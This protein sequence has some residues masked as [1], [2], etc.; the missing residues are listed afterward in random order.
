M[1]EVTN[2]ST[3]QATPTS[4]TP[5]EDPELEAAYSRL[6]ALLSTW[7]P[8]GSDQV[9]LDGNLL[10]KQSDGAKTKGKGNVWICSRKL[11]PFWCVLQQASGAVTGSSVWNHNHIPPLKRTVSQALL[12]AVRR[13]AILNSDLS[14]RVIY[15][16]ELLQAQAV[17]T[18]KAKSLWKFIPKLS[19]VYQ[20]IKRI[21]AYHFSSDNAEGMMS[22]LKMLKTSQKLHLKKI[23]RRKIKK[24]I[25]KPTHESNKSKYFKSKVSSKSQMESNNIQMDLMPIFRD[26]IIGAKISEQLDVDERKKDNSCNREN[27]TLDISDIESNNMTITASEPPTIISQTAFS[28]KHLSISDVPTLDPHEELDISEMLDASMDGTEL[29]LMEPCSSII[30][31][32][33]I[34]EQSQQLNAHQQS[35]QDS[36]PSLTSP[37]HRLPLLKSG[38]QQNSSAVHPKAAASFPLGQETLNKSELPSKPLKVYSNLQSPL[39]LY[40]QQIL[41]H[42]QQQQKFTLQPPCMFLDN[43]QQKKV[44]VSYQGKGHKESRKMSYQQQNL[45][46]QKELSDEVNFEFESTQPQLS[47]QSKQTHSLSEESCNTLSPPSCQSSKQQLLL[48]QSPCQQQVS[49]QIKD[50]S[51]KQSPCFSSPQSCSLVQPEA[52]LIEISGQ[53]TLYLPLSSSP[54]HKPQQTLRE[55]PLQSTC[56][57]ITSKPISSASNEAHNIVSPISQNDQ[58]VSCEEQHPQCHSQVCLTI[59][60]FF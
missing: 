41:D 36:N 58:N 29:D 18:G 3:P 11:C 5:R 47:G 52:Q 1:Q 19:R 23:Q 2:L 4:Y 43:Q 8:D 21:R 42:S 34:H 50:R 54:P 25:S 39:F 22:E 15:Q 12:T 53:D 10:L 24:K 44:N 7:P 46:P 20:Q 37:L 45:Y 26:G 30:L 57:V 60:Q 49:Q 16:E 27:P 32:H 31:E 35:Q 38:D 33:G 17:L 51:E 9:I 55:A 56:L 13:R 40:Q 28:S 48:S 59:H 14:P 6:Q